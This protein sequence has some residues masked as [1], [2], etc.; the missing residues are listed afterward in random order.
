[1]HCPAERGDSVREILQKAGAEEVR[2]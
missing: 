2:A 1:V